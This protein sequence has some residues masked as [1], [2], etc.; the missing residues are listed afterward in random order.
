MFSEEIHC[1]CCRQS[2]PR[3]RTATVDQRPYCTGCYPTVKGLPR[4][5]IDRQFQPTRKLSLREAM[6][7]TNAGNAWSGLAAQY[8]DMLP[9]ALDNEDAV[10]RL[11]PYIVDS[12]ALPQE[13]LR[14]KDHLQLAYKTI[15]TRQIG[16]GIAATFKM[17]LDFQEAHAEYLNRR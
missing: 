7:W 5:Q 8:L 13:L 9:S 2:A 15:P 16:A 1:S 3:H 10:A 17:A 4:L 14:Y 12:T 11:V 6:T